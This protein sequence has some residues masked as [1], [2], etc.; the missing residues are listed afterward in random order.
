[1]VLGPDAL[2]GRTVS[3]VILHRQDGSSTSL[4][5][6]RSG[7]TISFEMDL[8]RWECAVVEVQT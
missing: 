8:A 5:T 3:S 2:H 4:A 1:V 6:H 7:E